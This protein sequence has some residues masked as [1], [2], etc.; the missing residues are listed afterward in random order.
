MA[1][2]SQ[3]CCDL[4]FLILYGVESVWSSFDYN[5]LKAPGASVEMFAFGEHSMRHFGAHRNRRAFLNFSLN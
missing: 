4:L 1:S 3:K 5:V 2:S